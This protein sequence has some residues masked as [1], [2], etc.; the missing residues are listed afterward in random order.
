MIDILLLAGRVLLIVLLYI[1]LFAI[2][3]TGIGL[4]KV[5]RK[6]EKI[7]TLTV[8]RGPKELRG[9]SIPVDKPVTVGRSSQADI[10]I[11]ASYV[12]SMH[13][14]FTLMGQNL[15]VEDLQSRNGTFVNNK[16][17][18]SPVALR[19]NDVVVI[20]N[21]AIRAR[22][23]QMPHSSIQQNHKLQ[24]PAKVRFE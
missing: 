3:R 6:K 21:V 2:M 23:E 16:E 4:V 22:F 5:Q 1:F 11:A 17:C 7:W 10:V 14:R 24:Q 19:D 13:A 12:S 20:G 8:E 18:T 15:F 9:V